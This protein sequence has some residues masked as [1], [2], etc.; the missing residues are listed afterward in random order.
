MCLWVCY[1]FGQDHINGQSGFLYLKNL[2]A[3]NKLWVA[4]F[5]SNDLRT[6]LPCI[7]GCCCLSFEL[8]CAWLP[9]RIISQTQFLLLFLRLIQLNVVHLP[10][11]KVLIWFVQQILILS[12][13]YPHFLL[14][15][16]IP[17]RRPLV[18]GSLLL[19]SV[20]IT[21]SHILPIAPS[22]AVV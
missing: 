10:L 12:R 18:K 3:D 6:I 13:C 4:S 15:V 5:S 1:L 22:T 19:P 21:S 11:K 14:K 17:R 9:L 20:A 16:S 2:K 8:Q 7:L